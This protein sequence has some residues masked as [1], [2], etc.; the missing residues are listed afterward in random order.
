MYYLKYLLAF[1]LIF[2]I[3]EISYTQVLDRKRERENKKIQDFFLKD[4]PWKRTEDSTMIIG[5]SYKIRVEEKVKGINRAISI[6]ASDSIAYKLFP[7]Y[8]ALKKIDYKPFLKG[9]KEVDF[10]IPVL[11]E[12]VGSQ[13][14]EYYDREKLISFLSNIGFAKVYFKVPLSMFHFNNENAKYSTENYTYLNPVI[15]WMDKRVGH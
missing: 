11:I 15:I 13:P 12:L 2:S 10:I 1:L 9:R 5:F 4:L 3:H 7:K 14:L 8:E 6:T